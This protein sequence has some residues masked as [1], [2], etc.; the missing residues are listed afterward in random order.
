MSV[1][2]Q[3]LK[4]LEQRNEQS[5]GNSRF[6]TSYGNNKPLSAIKIALIAL[7]IIV[8]NVLGIYTWNLY[9]ENK[10][11]K[12]SVNVT[13]N[14]SSNT[15]A[16]NDQST[17]ET[18]V[19]TKQILENQPVE[20]ISEFKKENTPTI[21]QITEQQ[22]S[23][24]VISPVTNKQLILVHENNIE[25]PKT[26][27]K[28]SSQQAQNL[29]T[30]E[31][32]NTVVTPLDDMME[33]E[34]LEEN[35]KAEV[36][37]EPEIKSSLSIS[38]S[39]LSPERVVQNKLKK[40]ERAIIDNEIPIAER[41][42]EDILLIQPENKGARKQLAA[43]WFGRRLY[44][45]ALNLLSQGMNIYPDDIDF[46]LMK[47]RILIS[48][49]NSKEAFNVLNDFSTVQNVEYQ[50]LLAN[51][52]QSLGNVNSVILAYKQLTTIED[53]KGKWWMGLAVALD[54]NSQFEEAKTAY[55]MALSK[56]SL[57]SNSAQFIRQRMTELG[58]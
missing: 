27:T 14:N 55:R 39:K 17:I 46:R 11:L 28:V 49:N 3:M 47:A 38:R 23:I 32:S 19:N 42:F 54:R 9:S 56:G 50:L 7:L 34:I 45:P 12:T 51:T 5:T 30:V 4:E 1:I 41:L 8:V 29:Q 53:Y 13:S 44:R 57:S 15:N 2:N 52:A 25:Q 20:A 40:A 16:S 21:H 48:Q 18:P 26:I 35:L 6:D 58:E 10:A 24:K 33:P 37:Q 31:Y 43:L 22:Q 36:T